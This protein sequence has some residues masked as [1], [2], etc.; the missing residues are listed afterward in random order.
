MFDNSLLNPSVKTANILA[1]IENPMNTFSLGGALGENLIV[2][3]KAL[4]ILVIGLIFASL[5]KGQVK[6]WLHKTEIDNKIAAWITNSEDPSSL[7]IEQWIGEIVGW[8][9]SLFVIVAF[10]N[11][12]DL[13]VVS[14]P[15]NALL[16]EITQFLPRIGG[17]V[18]LLVLA[19]ALA[20][21]IKL[22]VVSAL[23]KLEVDKRL[24][25]QIQEDDSETN[26]IALSE[27]IGNALYWFIY[28]LFLPALL[29]VLRLE[30]TLRPLE[31]LVNEIV[32][33][34][35]NVF[36]AIIIAAIGWVIA[37]IIKKVVTNLL[38]A[39][40]INQIGEKFGLGRKENSQSLAQIVGSVVYVLVLIPI[41]ITALDALQIDAI[42]T[43]ATEMLNQVLNI[44]PKL[45]AAI[46]IIGLAYV[47]GQYLSELITNLL[48]TVG[49]NNI[50][51]WLGVT[52]E[53][54]QAEETEE[55]ENNIQTT[56]QQTPSQIVGV[57][58]L[59]AVMLVASLT[60]VDILEID[61]LRSVV[62]FIL[63]LS[64][65]IL[66]GL[67]VFAIGLYFANLVFRLIANSG[68]NQ[69]NF[70]AQTA[71]IAIIVMV[72]AMA[73]ER[74]GIAPNIVN[75]AFGLLTGGIAV[76]IALAFGLG[77]REVAGKVLEDWVNNFKK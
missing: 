9:I 48:T 63:V 51:I 12:L 67:L 10:L 44:L 20:T 6:K 70:L 33:I 21:V 34:L 41:A 71:R 42:S 39:S 31:E 65:Q 17:A 11:A 61:A 14:Q 43:P 2:I 38:M 5:F 7:P 49:F 28:L 54:P 8:I 55:A 37:Q 75:L 18:L 76:A 16:Q 62:A 57:I 1:Q 15:L 64:G 77:G 22:L 73:L 19:W 66:A 72:S 40:G 69:A 24:N 32:G 74:I 53:S 36:A 50:F 3:A 45:F 13:E 59:V 26:T 23:G 35:P 56:A 68:T 47:A 4:L 46:V 30:G 27:T 58:V 29:G 52:Q 25:Q 60:A